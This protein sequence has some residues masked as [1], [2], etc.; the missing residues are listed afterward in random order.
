MSSHDARW[1]DWGRITSAD[2]PGQAEPCCGGASAAD[3]GR[4]AQHF[5]PRAATK[6]SAGSAAVGAGELTGGV[7]DAVDQLGPCAMRS[8]TSTSWTRSQHA[9]L[10]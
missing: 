2:C 7:P 5:A 3:C 6:R 8:R 4:T 10:G 9:D 1:R